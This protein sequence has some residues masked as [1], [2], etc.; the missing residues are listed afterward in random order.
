MMNRVR[1]G[2]M[3]TM[4]STLARVLGG[5]GA[6][7]AVASALSAQARESYTS[8]LQFGT[9]LIDIPV[10][11]ISPNNSDLWIQTSGKV[12]NYYQNPDAANF[13]TK[14]NSNISI[15]THWLGRFSVGVS[16]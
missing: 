7:L 6:S 16:A 2:H 10:A 11:W 1:G 13:A 4:R 14:V 12:F 9:G 3:R 15:D 8:T 5:V